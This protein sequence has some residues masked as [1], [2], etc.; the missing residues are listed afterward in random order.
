MIPLDLGEMQVK[1]NH[2]GGRT[3]EQ[4]LM[5]SLGEHEARQLARL[6]TLVVDSVISGSPFPTLPRS[7]SARCMSPGPVG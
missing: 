1:A 3:I 4:E 7:A 5:V 6:P 2:P